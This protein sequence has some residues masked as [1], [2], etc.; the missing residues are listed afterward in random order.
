MNKLIFAFA[1]VWVCALCNAAPAKE[2]SIHPNM[3]TIT[4]MPKTSTIAEGANLRY[5]SFAD[6]RCPPDVIC[7]W[8]GEIA[9]YFTLTFPTGAVEPFA[10]TS[11]ARAHKSVQQPG[12]FI[13]LAKDPPPRSPSNI[14][15][16]PELAVTLNI[17]QFSPVSP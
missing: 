10:L 16:D 3:I 7:I 17:Y 12:L 13:V 11:R 14:P 15:P 6:S 1:A 5:E 9:F 8:A 2:E 4:L